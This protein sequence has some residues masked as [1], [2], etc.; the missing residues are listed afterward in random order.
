MDDYHLSCNE[1]KTCIFMQKI[2]KSDTCPDIAQE[3][4][5]AACKSRTGLDR[6]T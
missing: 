2:G 3:F 6:P 5:N 4:P 1:R